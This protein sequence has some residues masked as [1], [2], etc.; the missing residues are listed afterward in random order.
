M[1]TTASSTANEDGVRTRRS[2]KDD[3]DSDFLDHIF[4]AYQ[5]RDEDF[6]TLSIADAELG[7]TQGEIQ[8][9]RRQ[10]EI[11]AQRSHQEGDL[12]HYQR[13]SRAFS[14]AS[15]SSSQEDGVA[16]QQWL[17]RA[18]SN[19]PD[20]SGIHHKFS[21]QHLRSIRVSSRDIKIAPEP[22]RKF[23]GAFERTISRDCSGGDLAI[24]T[25]ILRQCPHQF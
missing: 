17:P 5:H 2:A 7:L 15:R 21:Q 20:L 6:E 11:M 22:K 3:D 18:S 9:L 8:L 4:P 14:V 23:R 24:Q 1:P 16:R 25:R 19:R 13:T 10:Q 12:S